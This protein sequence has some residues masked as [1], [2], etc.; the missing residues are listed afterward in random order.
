MTDDPFDYAFTV[1]LE[2]P[3]EEARERAEAALKEQGFGVITEIDLRKTFRE[4][5]DREFRR[6]AILGACNPNLAIQALTAEPRVGL[7]LPC[8]VI[9]HEDETGEGSVV[10]LIDPM[11]MLGETSQPELREVAETA[12]DRLSRVAEALAQPA[13]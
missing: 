3:Y 4:K 11:G 9:V 2:A 6:Y 7:L 10:S 5:L 8:N 12:H 13:T 1:H